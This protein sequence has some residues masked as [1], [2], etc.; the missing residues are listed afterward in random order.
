MQPK[1]A[2]AWKRN[3]KFGAIMGG[4]MRKKLDHGIY[5]WPLFWLNTRNR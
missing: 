2:T 5:N 4:R 1:K 3:R